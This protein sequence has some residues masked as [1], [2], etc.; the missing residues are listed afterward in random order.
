MLSALRIGLLVWAW[1]VLLVHLSVR[2]Q[3]GGDADTIQDMV[4]KVEEAAVLR[5]REV[6]IVERGVAEV[7]AALEAIN[8]LSTPSSGESPAAVQ[9]RI[10]HL[11]LEAVGERATDSD[12]GVDSKSVAPPAADDSVNK[13]LPAAKVGPT[14]DMSSFLLKLLHSM[15]PGVSSDFGSTIKG[16]ILEEDMVRLERSKGGLSESDYE[17]RRLAI[18]RRAI[19][20]EKHPVLR[21]L[22]VAYFRLYEALQYKRR[23]GE[24]RTLLQPYVAAVERRPDH[25]LYNYI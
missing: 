12:E 20:Y 1:V 18:D 25:M 14:D 3:G 4:R 10:R 9:K 13:Y 15:G 24:L 19:K 22:V 17:T 21:A 5:E 6:G 8:A 16:L 7:Q 23:I 2:Q 11:L